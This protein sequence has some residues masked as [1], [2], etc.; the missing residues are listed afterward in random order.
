MYFVICLLL[1][2]LIL[3][4]IIVNGSQLVLVLGNKSNYFSYL[5]TVSNKSRKMTISRINNK[6]T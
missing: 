1:C 5:C 6:V 2:H 4:F 3:L